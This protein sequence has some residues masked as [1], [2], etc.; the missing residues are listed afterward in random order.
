VAIQ[1]NDTHPALAIA[2]LQRY[3]VDEAGLEWDD[4]WSIVS[5][6][7]SYTNHT[8]MPEALEKWSAALLKE[9][10]PRH[11]EI[12][13][14][15]DRR[16][17]REAERTLG[18]DHAT[19]AKISIFEHGVH[20]RVRMANVAV[21]GSHTVNGVAAI[22]SRLLAERLF[23]EFARLWPGKFT[24]VTNGITPR[25]WLLAANPELSAVISKR[26]G[27]AWIT[28]LDRLANLRAYAEDPEF[29]GE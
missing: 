6:T 25:R 22:H 16:F 15:I 14:E 24:N 10:V 27:N 12:L 21:I 8:L 18:K 20:P 13:E 5:H 28:D 3:F 17:M 2:E 7:I 11:Y 23:P 4:A 19:L 9:T 1:L 29:L 26:L